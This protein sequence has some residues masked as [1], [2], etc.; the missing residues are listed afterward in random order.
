MQSRCDV[1]VLKGIVERDTGR[2]FNALLR[3]SK[4]S[5]GEVDLNPR[6]VILPPRNNLYS[7]SAKTRGRAGRRMNSAVVRNCRIAETV[8]FNRR[9]PKVKQTNL[10]Q[11][12]FQSGSR[13]STVWV[14]ND[15]G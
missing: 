13:F 8:G 10:V 2:L 9:G 11:P 6:G 12:C 15:M 1:P 5:F 4:V 7:L 3:D 14:A